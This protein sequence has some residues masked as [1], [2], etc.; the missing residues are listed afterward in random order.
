MDSRRAAR[1]AGSND[2]DVVHLVDPSE[3][4]SVNV[5]AERFERLSITSD[6]ERRVHNFG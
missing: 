4:R 3:E 2:D 6:A 5:I 1:D